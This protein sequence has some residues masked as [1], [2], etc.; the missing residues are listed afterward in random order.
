MRPGTGG[1]GQ[2]HGAA[3]PSPCMPSQQ[4][5]LVLCAQ[6]MPLSMFPESALSVL[7]SRAFS[8]E[9]QDSTRL[10]HA[11]AHNLAMQ[12]PVSHGAAVRAGRLR[13]LSR[14]PIG[15]AWD[16]RARTNVPRYKWYNSANGDCDHNRT[17][18]KQEN[19]QE[20]HACLPHPSPTT[21][22]RV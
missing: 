1:L 14:N 15:P 12:V 9:D 19:R 18:L 5:H 6:L 4:S 3:Y 22:Y 20:R 10:H 11:H 17:H 2:P 13:P 16:E 8:H 7:V 21:L